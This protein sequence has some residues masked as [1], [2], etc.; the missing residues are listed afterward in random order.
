MA[1]T[2]E[3]TNTDSVD[4]II[5]ETASWKLSQIEGIKPPPGLAK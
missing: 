5:A 4:S 3:P 2:A 1:D